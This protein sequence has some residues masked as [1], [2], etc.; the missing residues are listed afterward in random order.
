LITRWAPAA[1]LFVAAALAGGCAQGGGAATEAGVL[2]PASGSPVEFAGE[3][4]SVRAWPGDLDA[5][6]SWAIGQRDVHMAVLEVIEP[7]ESVRV[8]A[9]TTADD[10]PAWLRF[11][12]EDGAAMG[13]AVGRAGGAEEAGALEGTGGMGR[14][15]GLRVDARVGR[16]GDAGREVALLRAVTERLRALAD[17]RG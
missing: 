7:R 13:D 3:A 4:V 5:A 1:C 6:V 15:V 10:R 16:F 12:R 11:T 17:R 8:Y 14:G 9:L 2:E